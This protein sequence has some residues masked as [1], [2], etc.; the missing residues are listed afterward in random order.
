MRI[1]VIGA[2]AIGSAIAAALVEAGQDT[3][4]VARGDRLATLRHAPLRLESNGELREV[5]VDACAV[6][7]LG[8]GSI[9]MAICCVKTP[10]LEPALRSFGVAL[11]PDAALL[12]LQ[13]G[14]ESHETAARLL[15]DAAIVA[16]R[17]HGFFEMTGDVVRHVGVAP[18]ILLGSAQGNAAA[19]ARVANAFAGSGIAARISNDITL[20][21]WE[22]F[23]LAASLGSVGA[24]LGTPAGLVLATAEG[25]ALL[26]DAMAEIVR[27]AHHRGIGL[28][29]GHIA[30]TL[31]FVGGFPRDATTSLQRDLA[32][33]RPSEYDALT[34]AVPRLAAQSGVAVSVFPE[35]ERMIAARTIA[36]G[37]E[38]P[39]H[40]VRGNTPPSPQER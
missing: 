11:S 16:G 27:L 36:R 30:R 5:G 33:Q 32:A 31:A 35:L 12:T 22:K 40:L 1:A 23:L 25:E 8:E 28:D 2:G 34:A 21:L 15:P 7:D 24:A 17:M 10:G 3:V 38:L 29:D 18:S 4:L 6:E 26:R 14:V 9:A 13:N 37:R 20:A 19:E 39:C